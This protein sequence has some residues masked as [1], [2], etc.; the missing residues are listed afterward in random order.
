MGAPSDGNDGFVRKQG[1]KPEVESDS[2]GGSMLGTTRKSRRLSGCIT[3]ER[4]ET[5]TRR[6]RRL[7]GTF[8]EDRPET[9][10]RKGR[11]LSGSVAPKDRSATFVLPLR[12]VKV[13]TN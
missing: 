8:R 7:S 10:T 5:P 11:L 12:R 4:Q 13:I 2:T 1:G 3:E 9:P 6:S